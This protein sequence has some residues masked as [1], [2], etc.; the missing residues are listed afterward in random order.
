MNDERDADLFFAN[1]W[2][3]STAVSTDCTNTGV[4]LVLV[5]GRA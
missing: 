3:S 5:S 1:V 2:E 4:F